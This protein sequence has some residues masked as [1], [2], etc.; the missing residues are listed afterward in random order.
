MLA[1]SFKTAYIFIVMMYIL[2][3]L[4][5]LVLGIGQMESYGIMDG[6]IDPITLIFLIIAIILI[7]KI[8]S[9]LGKHDDYDRSSSNF[10]PKNFSK[11][12]EDNVIPLPEKKNANNN[13]ANK[14]VLNDGDIGKMISKTAD[15]NKELEKNLKVLHA[16]DPRFN[17]DNFI[18]GAKTA[19]EM[20]VTAFAEDDRKTLSNL[21]AEDV[22]KGFEGALDDRADRGHVVNSTMVGISRS[23]IMNVEL[24]GKTAEIT[25]KFVSEMISATHDGDGELIDGDPSVVQDVT[26]VWTFSRQVDSE[27]LNWKLVATGATS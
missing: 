25:V 3:G 11:E 16:A 27:N 15:G 18:S 22:F 19:Y 10:D 24:D 23:E 12:R 20:I 8:R 26:D 4:P 14:P 13:Q 6:N 21:L 9:V 17:P 5:F 2:R 7:F 1:I